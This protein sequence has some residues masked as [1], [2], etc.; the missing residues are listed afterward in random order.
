MYSFYLIGIVFNCLLLTDPTKG[1]NVNGVRQFSMPHA[2]PQIRGEKIPK[3]FYDAMEKADG[4]KQYLQHKLRHFLEHL[5]KNLTMSTVFSDFENSVNSAEDYVNRMQELSTFFLEASIAF[6]NFAVESEMFFETTKN[7]SYALLL[8]LRQV[9]KVQPTQAKVLLT[10]YFAEMEFFH[11]Y[12]SE[13]VDEAFEYTRT[14]L[15]AIQNIFF[16]YADTQNF[17]LNNWKLKLDQE[18]CKLYVDF[19][20]H[21]SAQIF[22]CAAMDKLNVAYDVFAVTKINLK[23]V[24]KELEFRVQRL[25]NCFIF[26]SYAIRCRFLN[27]AERDFENLFSKLGELEMYLDIKTKNGRVS[28]SR[29]RRRRRSWFD[30]GVAKKPSSLDDCISSDFPRSQMS[31]DLKACFYFFN[32]E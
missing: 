26:G 20:H 14:T 31:S 5:Q 11:I 27:N 22:K 17:I 19:L 9:P 7:S 3:E 24:M 1:A 23:Y 15:R 12:F 25:F 29:L 28:A 6:G 10:N 8:K 32:S 21:H 16:Y 13:V 18:C 2:I 4:S 30:N